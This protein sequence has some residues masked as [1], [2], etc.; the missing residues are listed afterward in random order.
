MIGPGERLS[1]RIVVG[2]VLQLWSRVLGLG[3]WVLI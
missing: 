3:F 2:M 1:Y